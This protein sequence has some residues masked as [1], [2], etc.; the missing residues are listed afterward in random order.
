[1]KM[2]FLSF[3]FITA[4]VNFV[5]CQNN[6]KT[7]TVA[8]DS[9]VVVPTV[10]Y[11]VTRG[12]TIIMIARKYRVTPREIYTLNPDAVNGISQ[13]M[14]LMLPEDKVRAVDQRK[15]PKHEGAYAASQD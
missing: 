14:V 3:V 6:T 8:K 11:R 1:M 12:E 15:K 2:R 5:F 10:G 9:V 4:G 7:N 13:N